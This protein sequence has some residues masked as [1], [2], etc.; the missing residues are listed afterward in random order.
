MTKLFGTDD[1]SPYYRLSTAQVEGL[2]KDLTSDDRSLRIVAAQHIGRFVLEPAQ[3][4]IKYITE[5]NCIQTLTVKYHSI[6]YKEKK[7]LTPS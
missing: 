1:I 3:A 4:L 7:K 2:A 6:S 5:G